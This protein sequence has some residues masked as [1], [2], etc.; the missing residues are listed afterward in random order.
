MFIFKNKIKPLP[1]FLV[2]SVLILNLNPKYVSYKFA[3]LVHLYIRYGHHGG[4]HFIFIR[5][6]SLYLRI[7]R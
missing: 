4:N 1:K 2:I 6:L 5:L 7:I 3:E